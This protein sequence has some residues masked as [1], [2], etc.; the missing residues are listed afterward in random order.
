ME[1]WICAVLLMCMLLPAA[2]L[3]ENSPAP[4]RVGDALPVI[5]YWAENN[6]PITYPD[7]GWEDYLT[8]AQGD[9]APD[10]YC[11]NTNTDDFLQ[12]KESRLLADLSPSS[13]GGPSACV[14]ISGGL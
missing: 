6:I 13:G 8:I 9:K 1:K 14:P 2:A 12:A 5:D 10:L 7:Y 11:F 3:A 4:L